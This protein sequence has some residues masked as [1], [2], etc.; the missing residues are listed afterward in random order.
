MGDADVAEVDVELVALRFLARLADRHHDAPPVGVFARAGG[1]HQRRV[2]DR[3]GDAFGGLARRRA[4][5]IDLDEFARS[6]AVADHLLGE[7][8]QDLVER[9]LE[10]GERLVVD[11][12]DARR[13]VLTSCAGGEEEQRSEVEVSLSTVMQLN[14]RCTDFASSACS[15]GAAIGASVNTNDSIVAMSGAI[16]PAPFAMPL[17]ETSASPSVIR[18]VATLGKVSV[19][20]IARAASIMA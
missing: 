9:A 10:R 13:A 16:M 3:H 18:C 8:E 2:G 15:T 7:A 20:R 1:F 5:D 4:F 14:E 17:M 11:V 12:L 6:L 19:V